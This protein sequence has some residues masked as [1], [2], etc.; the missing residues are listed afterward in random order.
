MGLCAPRE[1]VGVGRLRPNGW[2][3]RYLKPV[4]RQ[5]SIHQTGQTKLPLGVPEIFDA[6]LLI[7]VGRL[8]S[9]DFWACLHSLKKT[10]QIRQQ[11][12]LKDRLTSHP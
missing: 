8:R 9:N 3:E 10:T 7:G 11:P 4:S 12:P 6:G 1:R 5:A 2:M